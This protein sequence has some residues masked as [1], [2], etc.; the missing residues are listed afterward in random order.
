M[1]IAF[2]V[3]NINER[4]NTKAVWDYAHFNKTILKNE[5][6]LISPN[7]PTNSSMVIKYIKKDIP[8]FL[9]E[10]NDKSLF[11][12]NL[13]NK[14][15]KEQKCNVFYMMKNESIPET[16]KVDVSMICH[17]ITKVPTNGNRN[18]AISSYINRD[19]VPLTINLYPSDKNL[20]KELSIPKSAVVF[21]RHGGSVSF[22]VE[23]VH[24][25]ITNIVKKR[26]DIYFLFLNTNRFC[27]KNKNIIHLPKCNERK[28]TMFINTCD[29]MIHAR[30][31][32]ECFGI[33]VG[34]FSIK[35]KPVITYPGVRRAHITILNEKCITYKDT[36]KLYK[37]LTT[38][39]KKEISKKNWDAYSENYTPEPVMKKFKEFFLDPLGVK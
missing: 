5:S 27:K 30:K 3:N 26:K 7:Q 6:I 28:K 25:I 31:R 20:R 4:G 14:I 35:N 24:K 9:Y 38:F 34:E 37:I 39:N 19:F 8:I 22:N 2:H 32:G 18:A 12:P 11:E 17:G 29:A 10:T 23:F 16:R 1:K 21:G 15:L 36:E 13:I 33:A